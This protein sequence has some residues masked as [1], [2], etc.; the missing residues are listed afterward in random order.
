M[1]NEETAIAAVLSRYEAAANASDAAAVVQLYADDGVLMAQESRSCV[2]AAAIRAAYEG[3]FG[4][5]AL[6]IRFEIA[7]I[8]QLAPEWA[9]L[10]S[11]SS[12]T[13]TLKAAGQSVPEGNQELFLL[14]KVDGTWKIARYCFSTTLPAS[15]G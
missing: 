15:A 12:G 10:R 8:R 7:E 13:I 4:A 6:A 2:G 5:I 1:T 3:M 9:F 14:Q 11:T